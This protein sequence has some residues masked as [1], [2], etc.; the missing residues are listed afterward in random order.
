MYTEYDVIHDLRTKLLGNFVNSLA[1]L[2]FQSL[3]PDDLRN[4]G[5]HQGVDMRT[6]ENF[7]DNTYLRE[8]HGR[9]LL[10]LRFLDRESWI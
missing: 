10:F 8:G 6:F 4:Q 1:P 5:V 9:R 7:H 3:K 2:G